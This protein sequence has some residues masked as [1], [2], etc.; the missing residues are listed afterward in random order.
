MAGRPP[1]PAAHSELTHLCPLQQGLKT[2]SLLPVV[3][4]EHSLEGLSESGLMPVVEEGVLGGAG[5]QLWVWR[6]PWELTLELGLF[7]RQQLESFG[8]C[9]SNGVLSIPFQVG[10]RQSWGTSP[11][12]KLVTLD[13]GSLVQIQTWHDSFEPVVG[14][15]GPNIFIPPVKASSLL[16]NPPCLTV[17]VRAFVKVG[18][19]AGISRQLLVRS[20]RKQRKHSLSKPWARKASAGSPTR[21][22]QRPL[23]GK[24]CIRIGTHS[25]GSP[26]W[27]Q[28][29]DSI[30]F[31]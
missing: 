13:M 29:W 22:R 9:F 17:K 18:M 4:G 23:W 2:S 16:Q 27:P 5:L 15:W 1:T 30:L 26:Q 21:N 6:A 8:N 25:Q 3:P 7:I 20:R 10:R 14:R 12:A 19:H 11:D 28:W 31:Y 24:E